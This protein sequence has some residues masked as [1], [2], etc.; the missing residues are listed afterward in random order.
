VLTPAE[1]R[2][3][4]KRAHAVIAAGLSRKKQAELGLK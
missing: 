3:Y 4:L 1:T 2:A